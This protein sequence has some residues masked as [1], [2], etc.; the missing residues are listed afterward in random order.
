MVSGGK[1]KDGQEPFQ[2]NTW[3]CFQCFEIKES[4]ELRKDKIRRYELLAMFFC[5][6]FKTLAIY[7]KFVCGFKCVNSYVI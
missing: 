3:Q 5:F 2:R 1:F 6:S 4:I 7:F